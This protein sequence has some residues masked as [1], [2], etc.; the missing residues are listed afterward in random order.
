MT[1][2]DIVAALRQEMGAGKETEEIIGRLENLWGMA[3][4]LADRFGTARARS[5]VLGD[6]TET[7]IRDVLFAIHDVLMKG[8][9]TSVRRGPVEILRL[10]VLMAHNE[11]FGA[12]LPVYARDEEHARRISGIWLSQHAHLS[13]QFVQEFPNGFDVE[14]RYLPG[15]RAARRQEPDHG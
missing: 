10:F 15:T 14:R 8:D 6:A 2:A 7:P 4:S 1:R 9:G 13:H 12:L 3:D 11:F 5:L